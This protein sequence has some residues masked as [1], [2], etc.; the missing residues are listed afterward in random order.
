MTNSEVGLFLGVVVTFVLGLGNLWYNLRHGKRTAFVNTVTS[1]RI[2]WIARIREQVSILCSLC[3]QWIW[4]RTQDNTADLQRQIEQLKNEIT[5]QLNPNDAEDQDLIRLLARLPSLTKLIETA[6][7]EVLKKALI[8]S[9]QALLKR[10][11]DKVKDESMRGDLRL[12][13]N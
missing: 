1:E 6:D 8:S 2:K 11:W 12:K 3:D 9:T 13:K 4:F 5:M 10:E 7:F